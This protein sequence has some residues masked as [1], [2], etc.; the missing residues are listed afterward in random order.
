MKRL[1][2]LTAGLLFMS[3]PA[4]LLQAQVTPPK[5][6][7]QE[8]LPV[9]RVEKAV[10]DSLKKDIEEP[11]S[12]IHDLAEKLVKSFNAGKADEVAS[13]FVEQG[14]WID[15]DG[16]KYEGRKSIQE[17]LTKYFETFPGAQISLEVEGIRLLG[18]LAI[19]EGIRTMTAGGKASEAASADQDKVSETARALVHYVAVMIKG[20]TGWQLAS[21][22]DTEEIT[23]PTAHAALQP[24]D[25]LVGDWMNEGS[26]SQVQIHYRWDDNKNYII[27]DYEIQSAGNV[28]L[29]STHR[30]GF[31]P[32]HGRVHSWIFDSDG[33]FGEGTWS[34]VGDHWRIQSSAIL[35]DGGTGSAV[36]TLTQGGDSRFTLRGTD[37]LIDGESAD[38]F[39]LNVVRKAP[40]AGATK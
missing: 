17:V 8:E 20:D 40:A 2:L 26:G 21:V 32:L 31:D 14:E 24:L 30:I 25:W 39:E 18:P 4:S 28:V 37:R 5:N 11:L 10:E 35:P 36:I 27:G 6:S 9:K 7:T 33:G 22:Q 29:K 1:S 3:V 38:D 23:I 19:E 13:L 16:N 34:Q 12:G 15:D